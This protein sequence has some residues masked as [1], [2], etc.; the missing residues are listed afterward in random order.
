MLLL[1]LLKLN[2][3]FAYDHNIQNYHPGAEQ[4]NWSIIKNQRMKVKD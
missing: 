3:N 1:L 4:E 2:K